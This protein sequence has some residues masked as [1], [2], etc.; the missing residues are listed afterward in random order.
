MLEALAWKPNPALKVYFKTGL[1]PYFKLW[2]LI[3][4]LNPILKSHF[5]P[6][7]IVWIVDPGLKLYFE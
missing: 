2:T 3:W 4:D 6:V 5:E 1:K 7:T